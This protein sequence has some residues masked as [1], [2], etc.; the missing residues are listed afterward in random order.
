[1]RSL[2]LILA[3][4][5]ISMV[6]GCASSSTTSGDPTL[7]IDRV[8]EQVSWLADEKRQGRLTGTEGERAA[9]EWLGEQLRTLGA[10]PL[11]G[12]DFL[13]PFEFT[14]GTTDT[15]T[16]LTINDKP[17]ASANVR[18]LSFSK[19]EKVSGDVVFAGYGITVPEG[20]DFGY[21]SYASL[22]VDGKIVLVLRYLPE[23]A[24]DDARRALSR[25]SGLRFKALTARENGAAGLLVVTGP[26]SPNA[27]E[28]A[29]LTFDTSIAGSGIVAATITDAAAS[30]LL[31]TSDRSL[32]D[33]QTELDTAN[34]HVSG[35]ALE[36]AQVELDV[37]LQRET[38]TGYNV[39]GVL[40]ANATPAR[41]GSLVIGAHYDHL[42]RG[43]AGNSLAG[44][45]EA[46]KVHHGADDNASGVAAVL[47]AVGRLR[48]R[49]RDVIVGFW[50][51]EE[52]GLIGSTH[53]VDK[54][55]VEPNELIAY[56]NFDMVGRVR[57][58][59]V[60]AQGVG[61][62]EQWPAI[63]ESANENLGLTVNLMSDPY[64][65]TDSSAFYQAQVP[66]LNF[67][68]GSH[69]DYHRPGDTADKLN[70]AGIVEVARLGANAAM[71]TM[72]RDE[73]AYAVVERK[74][75]SSGGRSG[76]RV[77][78]GTIPDYSTEVEGLLLGGVMAGGPADAAG[79]QK[80][81]VITGFAGKGV[82]NIYDYMYALDGVKPDV[83]IEVRYLRDGE[84]RTTTLTPKAR[85]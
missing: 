79:L 67:F 75:A 38:Q 37:K 43:N 54:S 17:V 53:F 26:N 44:K 81:D 41:E 12:N 20:Q 71:L 30:T 28:L 65:P 11:K 77:F 25:Y 31:A 23:N 76:I 68:S 61:S 72:D 18:G 10:Q 70:Y 51:G 7:P 35:F 6:V 24:G 19:S 32:A 57:E 14:A 58:N 69:E 46:G 9:A 15:G 27:G 2:R 55:G 5:L 42:G 59:S 50:S 49:T 78:T 60:S 4:S 29:P 33:L 83:P 22:D 63:V 66:T 52:L 56:I 64:L 8:R 73:L 80:G 13:Q 40:P 45:D 3:L 47:E 82:A 34:P 85:E 84:E 48:K 74:A 16:T 1:M 62:S 36:N 21:D 39:V